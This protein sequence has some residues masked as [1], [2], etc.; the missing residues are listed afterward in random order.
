MPNFQLECTKIQ[1][2]LGFAPDPAGG[3][4]SAPHT[5]SW[6]GG[7]WL[8]LP[9]THTAL[10]PSGLDLLCSSEKLFKKAVSLTLCSMYV[11][12]TVDT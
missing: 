6:W 12:E 7:G 1:F 5:P 8:P 3:A 9:R 4:Y 11:D 2:P 10:D